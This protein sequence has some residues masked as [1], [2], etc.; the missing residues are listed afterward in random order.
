MLDENHGNCI[1]GIGGINI[2]TLGRIGEHNVVI[3][4]LPKGQTGTN[5]AAAVAIQMQSACTSIRFGLMVDIGGGVP[6]EDL[7][8]RLGDVVAV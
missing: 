3:A 4:C 7:D 5:S 1:A 2:Y 8:I 6:S